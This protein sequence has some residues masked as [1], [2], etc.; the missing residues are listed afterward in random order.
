MG[1]LPIDRTMS[2][3]T[4]FGP[5]TP[6]KTS[7]PLIASARVRQGVSAAMRSFS[8]F[9]PSVRPFQTT[10]LLSV[11]RNFARSAPS[12]SNI[13][14]HEIP[15]APAPA[16]TILQSESRFPATSQAFRS[17]APEMIAVPCWSS[18]KTGMSSSF[19]SRDSTSKH[20]GALMSSRLMP[21][22]VGAMRRT[23]S[24]RASTVGASTSMSKTSMPANFLNRTPFPSITG[25]P[26]SGPM[27]PRPKIAVPFV[28]T[29]TRFP[30]FV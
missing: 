18:W 11:N 22:K 14:A 4:M 10:P 27:F 29:A 26:A 24:T 16:M 9:I 30:L 1:R 23:V 5:D 6:R 12:V 20:S 2:L 21:P 8:A 28:M 17:A 3:E 13:D 7:A 15:A 19:S 25:F